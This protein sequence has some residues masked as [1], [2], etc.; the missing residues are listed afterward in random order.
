MTATVTFA[1]VILHRAKPRISLN[2]FF[3]FITATGCHDGSGGSHC[4]TSWNKCG[5]GE[6]GCVTDYGCE[7]DLE[8]GNNNCNQDLGFPYGYDCCHKPSVVGV[9]LMFNRVI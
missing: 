2:E 9:L 5:E 8:C 7:G 1:N 3:T 6:G 4:C